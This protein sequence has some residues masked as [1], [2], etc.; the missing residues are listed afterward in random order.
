MTAHPGTIRCASYDEFRSFLG[1]PTDQA[2]EMAEFEAG[3][4]GAETFSVPGHCAV[5]DRDTAFLVDHQYCFVEPG[6]RR[7]PN[8]RERLTCPGCDLNNRMRAAVGFLLAASRPGDA[9]YVT[10]SVTPLFQANRSKRK[11]TVGSEYI[12]DGTTPGATIADGV[13]NEDV[14]RLT[15]PDGAF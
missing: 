12:R 10:G 8:W 11:R 4:L 2:A 3:L 7:V 14:T 15:F 9:V 6:G 13:R 1:S 5:C